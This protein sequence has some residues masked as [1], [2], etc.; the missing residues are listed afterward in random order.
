[1]SDRDV[2]LVSLEVR[3]VLGALGNTLLLLLFLAQAVNFRYSVAAKALTGLRKFV[4][5]AG[6]LGSLLAMVRAFVPWGREIL[7]QE[8][9]IWFLGDNITLCVLLAGYFSCYSVANLSYTQGKEVD[10]EVPCLIFFTLGVTWW[11]SLVSI[12]TLDTVLLQTGHIWWRGLVHLILACCLLLFSLSSWMLNRRM[13]RGFQ[14]LFPELSHE[15]QA[16]GFCAF[17][18]ELAANDQA[19]PPVPESTPSNAGVQPATLIISNHTSQGE[20]TNASATPNTPSYNSSGAASTQSAPFYSVNLTSPQLLD[21]N[22]KIVFNSQD[23]YDTPLLDGKHCCMLNGEKLESELARKVA[24]RVFRLRV[25]MSSAQVV[26]L[27]FGASAVWL[28]V[29]LLQDGPNASTLDRT[30]QVSEYLFSWGQWLALVII[31]WFSWFPFQCS[32]CRPARDHGH[33]RR[34]TKAPLIAPQR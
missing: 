25:A 30:A 9:V 12:N 21:P 18:R 19:A 5:L 15:F 3:Q 2:N 20:P 33:A 34:L 27:V 4:F 1:M 7:Y 24:R 16:L 14:R 28:G 6:L 11:L 29:G 10:S 13:H 17:L 32:F 8:N 22:G 31:L 26:G 23:A